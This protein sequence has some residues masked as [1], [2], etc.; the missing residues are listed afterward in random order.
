MTGDILYKSVC[1]AWTR[2]PKN[3][4]FEKE[5]VAAALEVAKE[6]KSKYEAASDIPLITSDAKHKVARLSVAL[7]CLLHSTDDTHEKVVVTKDHVQFIRDFLIEIYE[8]DN[9][10][11]NIYAALRKE[12]IDFSDEDYEKVLVNFTEADSEI[13]EGG[14]GGSFRIPEKIKITCLEFASNDVVERNQLA[15][16]LDLTPDNVTK[17]LRLFKELHLIKGKS[18]K[19]GYKVTAK[20]KKILKR[21]INEG[22]L[23]R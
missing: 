8:H 13:G 21:M 7:A 4:H 5:A 17:E 11:L 10:S 19:R 22:L 15:D 18:G 20:F 6:L 12:V 14:F 2:V 16:L 9:C 1:W 23:V 3:V